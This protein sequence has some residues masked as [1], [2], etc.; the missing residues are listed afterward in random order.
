MSTE[1][2]Q[3]PD[4]ISLTVT[5]DLRRS[6]LTVFFRLLLAIPHFVWWSLWSIAAAVVALLTWICALVTGRPPRAF[7]RFLG[8]F[9][10]YQTHLGGFVCLVANP[11]P[12]FLGA[13][14]SYPVDLET[15]TEPEQQKRL[16][17]LFRI[18]LAIP[19]LILERALTYLLFVIAFLGW[20]ASLIRGRMPVGFRDLGAYVLRYSGQLNGYVLFQTA[21]YPH[22]SPRQEF[23]GPP[24]TQALPS[25]DIGQELAAP[26]APQELPGPEAQGLAGPETTPEPP[27]PSTAP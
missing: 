8:A 4:P 20:F 5:D 9:I 15:P 23:A 14:G 17:T 21:R 6:R 26:E 12:G 22:S 25:P 3:H 18:I 10:R 24:P 13:R 1:Q 16:V 19:A 27:G 11:F 7:H 2:T